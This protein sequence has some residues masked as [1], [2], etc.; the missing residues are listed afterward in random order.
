MGHRVMDS[1]GHI[2]FLYWIKKNA[3][4]LIDA[5]KE[6]GLEINAE[7]NKYMLLSRHQIVGQ[8]RDIRIAKRSYENVSQFKY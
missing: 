5:S 2:N 3:E 6:A 1:Y 4:T 8:N 7:E